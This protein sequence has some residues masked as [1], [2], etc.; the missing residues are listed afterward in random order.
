MVDREFLN[1]IE[2]LIAKSENLLKEIKILKEEVSVKSAANYSAEKF[3]SEID[4]MRIVNRVIF[5]S[6]L[7]NKALCKAIAKKAQ[8]I[9]DKEVADFIKKFL[10]D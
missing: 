1:E 5:Y 2:Y 7:T 3:I 10:K 9:G 6:I 4:E 8:K